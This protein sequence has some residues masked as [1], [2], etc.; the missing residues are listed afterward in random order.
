LFCSWFPAPLR[1][2]VAQG[3][4]SL[5]DPMMLAAFGFPAAPH[6][7]QRASRRALR[8]RARLVRIL[9]PRRVSK[10]ARDPHNRSYPGYPVGYRPRDLGA[11]NDNDRGSR[12]A[13]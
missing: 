12:R 10:A 2:F 6:L 3:V 8:V 11:D 1:P 4:Y 13:A 7:L 9:P 5:L